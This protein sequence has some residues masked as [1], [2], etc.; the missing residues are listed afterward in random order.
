[1]LVDINYFMKLKKHENMEYGRGAAHGRKNININ[2]N[3]R[4]S[5]FYSQCKKSVTYFTK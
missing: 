4:M 2:L 5:R 3:W 1:V